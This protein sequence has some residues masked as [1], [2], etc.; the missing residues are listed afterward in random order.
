MSYFN[1]SHVTVYRWSDWPKVMIIRYFNTSH[2]TVYP[3]VAVGICNHKWFQ[4]I[5]CYCLSDILPYPDCNFLI[6]IHLML[7]FIFY[8]PCLECFCYDFN[9]SHVTVYRSLYSSILFL[10]TDF[11]TSHVTVY[12]AVPVILLVTCN[13]FNTSHVTVYHKLSCRK[14]ENHNISIHL[15]LLF[16]PNDF[17]F[18]DPPERFQ[19]ISCY[20]LSTFFHPL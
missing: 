20:C 19:Y 2:V 3:F 17:V 4:Y 16:I 15:M 8:S 13:H 9:T 14:K 11:N 18:C 6:S 12:L 10:F 7:L 5:S 1:T